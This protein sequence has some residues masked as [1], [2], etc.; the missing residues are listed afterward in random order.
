[1][2]SLTKETTRITTDAAM[3]MLDAI[4]LRVGNH[5]IPEYGMCAMEA[6]AWLAGERHTDEPRCACPVIAEFVRRLNDRMDYERRQQLRAFLPRLIGSRSAEHMAPRAE[7]LTRQA[8]TV[9][10]PLFYDE[11]GRSEIA[12]SLRALPDDASKNDLKA[13]VQVARR[14]FWYFR[15]MKFFYRKTIVEK[16]IRKISIIAT[17]ALRADWSSAGIVASANAAEVM[18]IAGAFNEK[19]KHKLW[20]AALAVL[21]GALQIGPAGDGLLTP[22]MIERLKAYG[23]LDYRGPG[24]SKKQ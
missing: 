15:Y 16:R 6:V 20:N 17:N 23:Q 9:F 24:G 13:A 18:Y 19:T 14:C 3:P 12:A 1:M 5:E 21:D 7:Y 2:A 10:L 22:A 8:V 11:L 4:V